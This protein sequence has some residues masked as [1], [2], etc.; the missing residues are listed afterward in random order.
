MGFKEHT[1]TDQ[2]VVIILATIITDQRSE[3]KRGGERENDTKS[4][5]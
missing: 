1:G 2:S 4:E 3:R 5:K